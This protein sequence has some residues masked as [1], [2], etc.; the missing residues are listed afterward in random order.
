[1]KLLESTA[2]HRHQLA[3]LEEAVRDVNVAEVSPDEVDDYIEEYVPEQVEGYEPPEA[4]PPKV[5]DT[6]A[7][8]TVNTKTGEVEDGEGNSHPEPEP[9]SRAKAAPE[10]DDP[11]PEPEPVGAAMQ[12][13]IPW[14][15]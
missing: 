1:M 5:F 8:K 15:F 13:E 14:A 4:S 3:L 12:E 6:G 9:K 2:E 11:D 7:G 10:N